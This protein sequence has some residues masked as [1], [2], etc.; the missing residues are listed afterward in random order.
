MVMGDMEMNTDL[1]VIG[2]GP[3]GYSAAF[4]AAELGLDV[5]LVDHRPRLG[6]LCL[7]A[8][9]IPS[10]TLLRLTRLLDHTRR[11]RQMGLR[12]AEPEIDLAAMRAW[13]QQL[14]SSMADKLMELGKRLGVLVIQGRARFSGAGIVHMEGAEISG[15]KF[16]QAIIATGSR[17][18]PLP[19][20]V[21]SPGNRIMDSTAALALTEIP[22]T[23][24]V[25]GGGY[26]GLEIGSI[27]AALGSRVTLME[28]KDRLLAKADT[29]LVA[30]L[31][32]RLAEHFAA[33]HLGTQV[34]SLAE[35]AANVTVRYTQSGQTAEHQADRA[36]LAIGRIPN[37]D[38]LGLEQTGVTLDSRGFIKIDEQQRTSDARIFA[39]GDVA[40]G[41]ML[42][43][44]ATRQGRVAAGT[45]SGKKTG[46]DVRAI[47]SVVYTEP[48]IAWCGLTEEKARREGIA[49]A[50]QR[51]PGDPGWVQTLGR[52]GGFTKLVI[53]PADGRILGIGMVGGNAEGFIGEAALAIEMGALAEDL[54]L[55]LHPYPT[56]AEPEDETSEIF[57]GSSGHVLP[58]DGV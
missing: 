31:Q 36:L 38:N 13:Q 46:F 58:N 7:H 24:L 15:I 52:P 27:Y 47:P 2:G 32:T 9:C 3:G 40:G 44:K 51:F 49:H 11:A 14:I 35:T 19:G 53:N 57:L 5:I 4:R 28:M 20:L 25:V 10:K 54:A 33:I 45:V 26:V 55:V 37:C 22:K 12:F 6:G 29:D 41:V 21:F 50:V 34:D 8:G 39:V 30:P 56:L 48:Q 43:H 1:L 42:A 17:P 16:K 18:R 23:L